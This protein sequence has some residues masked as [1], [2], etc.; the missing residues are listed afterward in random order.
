[1]VRLVPGDP[2]SSRRCPHCWF[3]AQHR[4]L[5]VSQQRT[6][7]RRG[8]EVRLGRKGG[9]SVRSQRP[10]GW[11]NIKRKK[12]LCPQEKIPR[13]G[14]CQLTLQQPPSLSRMIS[15]VLNRPCVACVREIGGGRAPII[16]KSG[17]TLYPM[18]RSVNA[19]YKHV[20]GG[21]AL[22]NK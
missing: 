5:R 14:Q 7:K 21:V 16:R 17:T 13:M 6:G 8:Y 19:W 12:G 9:W 4:V 22:Y 18:N 2:P 20:D 1:M 3:F 15:S 10:L 11:S